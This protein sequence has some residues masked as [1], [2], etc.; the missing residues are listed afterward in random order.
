MRIASFVHKY[1]PSIGGT[2]TLAYELS[3]RLIEYGYEISVYTSLVENSRPYEILNGIR[4][5]RF[6]RLRIPHLT[7]P[8]CL[9]PTM[10]KVPLEDE[11]RNYDIIHAFGY[12]TYQ[13]LVASMIKLIHKK[14]LVITPQFH[15]WRGMYPKTIGRFITQLADQVIAQCSMEKVCLEKFLGISNV[16]V[17]PVGIESKEFRTLPSRDTFREKY[18]IPK[19]SIMLLYVG[20]IRGHKRV[21]ELI[22]K[23]L[24]ILLERNVVFVVIGKD[25]LELRRYG[26]IRLIEGRRKLKV[27]HRVKRST[28]LE[29]YASADLYV[30]P[31]AHESFGISLLEAAA[32]GLPIVSTNVGVAP[33]IVLQGL[34]GYVSDTLDIE[35]LKKLVIKALNNLETLSKNARRI[36]REILE[37]YSWEKIIRAHIR[38]YEALITRIV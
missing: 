1:Y 3:K 34:N 20:S 33:D 31:S 11:I 28:V 25:A 2:Q 14:P 18:R 17:V 13:S 7:Y 36:R 29:A 5:Y 15:P 30:N 21:P 35:D 4:I 9:T 38:I 24:P 22:A 12:I 8:W 16:T 10:I 6:P 19:D 26:F 37:Y 32:C 27:L 23:L